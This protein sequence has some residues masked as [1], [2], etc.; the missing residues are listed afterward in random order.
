MAGG[1]WLAQ[2]KIRPGAYINFKSVPR[3]VSMVGTRGVVAIP[4]SL[5]WGARD[6]VIEIYSDELLTTKSLELLG[7]TAF[8]NDSKLIREA[9]RYSY[10]ALVYRMDSGGE[11]AAGTID[12]ADISAKYPGTVGNNITIAVKEAVFGDD[13]FDVETYFNG[14]IKDVQTVKE[15]SE[16]VGND[17]IDFQPKD[18]PLSPTAGITLN[19]GEDGIVHEK[20]AY[21]KFFEIMQDRTW[22]TMAVPTAD[23]TVKANA[24]TYI[25]NLRDG[26]GKYRQIALCDYRIADYEGVVSSKQGIINTSGERIEPE[27]FVCTVA[28]MTAGAEITQSNTYKTVIDAADIIN[29]I[30]DHDIETE[31]I[32]GNFVIRRSSYDDGIVIIEQD[33]NT[34]T[35]VTPE[36]NRD[37]SKNKIIRVLDDIGNQVKFIFET[38]YIGKVPN[39]DIGRNVFRNQILS[40]LLELQGIRAVTNVEPEDIVVELGM[41]LDSVVANMWVQPVDVM[42]KLYMT[43]EVGRKN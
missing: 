36:K 8:D 19:G 23:A 18:E 33:I 16:L 40:Y 2:N 24:V 28:G 39:D 22:N 31:L 25:K 15:S 5:K 17:W 26:Q 35:S 20:T 4:L 42:E 9:L 1:T 27:E 6:E 7:F 3:P 34:F 32:R 41:E 29:P 10:K 30:D 14:D 11:N 12:G 43:V 38:Q 21:P 37:F 13:L